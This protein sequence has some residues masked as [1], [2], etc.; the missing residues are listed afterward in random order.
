MARTSKICL[1]RGLGIVIVALTMHK[2]IIRYIL[3]IR[4]ALIIN[5]FYDVCWIYNSNVGT[6]FLCDDRIKG[7]NNY[8]ITQLRSQTFQTRV[9]RIGIYYLTGNNL[10]RYRCSRRK[11]LFYVT[12]NF[13]QSCLLHRS[14][15]VVC[16]FLY[17]Y[18][19]FYCMTKIFR[20]E[21]LRSISLCTPRPYSV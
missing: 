14:S 2:S 13:L 11:S 21:T 17:R 6:F 19:L 15:R 3:C 12:Y 18:Q 4:N 7:I 10:Y 1:H 20:I 5:A 8:R 16:H 9:N